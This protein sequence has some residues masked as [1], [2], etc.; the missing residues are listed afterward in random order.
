[1]VGSQTVPRAELWAGIMAQDA[2]K[3]SE[4]AGTI[5]TL[6]DSLYYVKGAADVSKS[7]D[8]TERKNADLWEAWLDVQSPTHAVR[9]VKAHAE[10]EVL[11]GDITV[12]DYLQNALA[13]AA[14]DAYADVIIDKL[15]WQHVERAEGIA[16]L[17][18]MRLA[19]LER[20]AREAMKDEVQV[21]IHPPP[22]P[23]EED[24]SM[25]AAEIRSSIQGRGHQL[26]AK[27][28]YIYCVRCRRRRKEHKMKDWLSISCTTN[29]SESNG[30][31]RDSPQCMHPQVEGAYI[32][33]CMDACKH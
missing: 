17:V 8:V 14:A 7:A 31:I 23:V 25:R 19:V 13:D 10:A 1:M 24:P 5:E 11:S 4:V 3:A 26:C 30:S 21:T 32:H 33:A 2:S 28:Q 16:Y 15:A 18:A 6:S 27:S 20:E 9:K 22:C 12:R 29:G